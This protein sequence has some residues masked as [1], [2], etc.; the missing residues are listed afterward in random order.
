MTTVDVAADFLVK[1]LAKAT[2]CEGMQADQLIEMAKQTSLRPFS[3]GE[4][5]ASPGEPVVEFVI[6]AEG[7][8]EAF[9][10]DARGRESRLGI[11]EPGET[12]GEVA[13]MEGTHRPIR[14]T[15]VTDGSVLVASA[16]TFRSWLNL[17]PALM[18]NLFRTLSTR[19]KNALGIKPRNLPARR[20]GVVA[21]SPRGRTLAAR[22]AARMREAG[23]R[24]RVCTDQVDPLRATGCWPDSF[25][26]EVRA[27]DESPFRQS[28]PDVDRHVVVWVA[29]PDSLGLADCDEVLWLV[30]AAEASAASRTGIC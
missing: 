30:D 3:A 18:R 4:T 6:V 27:A 22:L 7:R 5:I 9:L 12:I 2:L 20:L 19:F 28:S 11:V 23:E 8:I 17:Y 1:L 29:E 15:A 13:I 26:L 14:F 16:D 25:A 24:W 10:S 21:L